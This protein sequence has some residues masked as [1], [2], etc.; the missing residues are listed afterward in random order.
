MS[1]SVRQLIHARGV[2]PVLAA[3]G[4]GLALVVAVAPAA[5][6]ALDATNLTMTKVDTLK[7]DVDADGFADPG[8]TIHYTVRL[9]NTGGVAFS[10]TVFTDTIDA[11]T[12]LV[13]GSVNV[14]PLAFDD[15]YDTIGNTL[16]RV[17]GSSTAG[18]EVFVAGGSVTSNDV[19]FLGD[20]FTISSFSATSAN[21]GTVSVNGDGTFT[22]LPPVGFS[23][24]DT[25]T[26]TLRDDGTDSTPGNG[27]DLTGGG[28]VTINVLSMIWYV[29]NDATAGGLGRSSDPFDT[30]VEAQTASAINHTIYVFTGNG[31]T[32]GQNAGI[33][34]K[35][36]QR[37]V[38][39]GVALTMPIS[40]NGGPNPFT[41]R[42][43]GT[44]PRVD[45]VNVGGSGVSAT[46]VIPI[47]M[48]GLSLSGAQNAIDM[49]LTGAFG[50]T[51]TTAIKNNIFFGAGIEGLD[52][53][54]G[55]TGTLTLDI[56]TNSW[57]TAGSHGGNGVDIQR[58]AG[59]L[60]TSFSSNTSVL[61]TGGGNA[62]VIGGGA[63]AS[64]TITGF[65]DNTVNLAST[66]TGMNI[67]NVT[68]DAVPGGSYQQVSGGTTVV[69]A[70]GP[71]NGVAG[72]GVV[73]TTVNGDLAFTDLDIYADSGTGLGVTG[74]GAVNTGAGT[75]TRVTVAS[76]VSVIEATG[77]PA[78]AL[79]SM[80]ADLQ[81]VSLR[82][83]NS[84]ST[85]VLLSSVV[86][87]TTNS[88][89]SAGSTSSIANAGTTDVSISSGNA[90]VT[91]D[92]TITDDVGQ[93]VSVASNTGDTISFRGAITDGDDTDGGGVSLTGN[94]G[95][96]I[97]F[98]GGLVL[99]TSGN[100]A[101]AAT[102]GGTINVCDENPCNP[103]ATGTHVNKIE[104]TTATAL[105][106]A[107][108]MIGAN[109]LE[110]RSI[111]AGTGAGSSGVGISLDTT[112]TAAGNGGLKVAGTGSAG[113]GGTIQHKTGANASTTA[114]IGIYL[115][116][117]KA[118]SFTRMQLND[119]DN[120][121]IRAAEIDGLTLSNVVVSGLNGNSASD[122]EGAIVLEDA[123][124]TIALS[125]INVTGGFED[126]LRVVYDNAAAG[127]AATY[128]VTGSTF[129]DLQAAGQN[130]QVNL[131]STTTA[132]SSWNVAF[133]F[134]SS[135]VFENDANTLPPGGTEN[136]TD[137]ILV[138]FE[139]PFQHS[140][141]VRN[142]TFHHLFQGMDIASNFSADVN[143]TFV[144]NNITFTEGVAAIAM[145]S[146]SS[147]TSSSFL[148]A[149]IQGNNI[150]TSGVAQSGSRLGLGIVLDM[151]GEEIAQFTLHANNIRRTEVNGIQVIG[152]TVADGNLH[153]QLT[154]NLIEQIEDD[155]GGGAGVIYGVE[156]TTNTGTSH[157]ICLDARLN[158]SFNINAHDIR[159]RQSNALVTFDIEGLTGSGTTAA[160][161]EAFLV[162]Q[163]PGNTANVRTGAS[164]VNYTS[165]VSC[166]TPPNE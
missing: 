148:T 121:A 79:T 133:N 68:F 57:N 75:G 104:T 49:T 1:K 86:D 72:S 38:G 113:S 129:R 145:G 144:G 34:L 125:S 48:V 97:N 67:S 123:G 119:F 20:S 160:N 81:L 24:V 45:N 88:T 154:N 23:G 135:C 92:G 143:Y 74:S 165:V 98:Q 9:T 47:E 106:V 93:L 140:L 130:S 166:T 44:H 118:A 70:V 11:N 107:N 14:S 76:G 122:D 22:Y 159:V 31:T 128:N 95:A 94:T 21:G 99:D 102:G 111:T 91:Y 139:G 78:L 3:I 6:S 2:V 17:G 84:T 29:K 5:F 152:Q 126:N 7:T 58:T 53:N 147:S 25:F 146:G 115:N 142:S 32:A 134:T 42:A 77:G 65:A 101:F 141:N 51:G 156:V 27:D 137:G 164:I 59:T 132:S 162:A 158:D 131:K 89:I 15:S 63:V 85:G 40:V 114:G 62:I 46:D 117:T 82:S 151:R 60:R 56:Q 71:G 69:G 30:L 61:S 4:L 19:E 90:T 120:F 110:F 55:G 153:L 26:Y 105:N 52:V 103:G 73:M 161:V 83:T 138:T 50:G 18:P 66:G 80:T 87:G 150:G 12:A 100:P 136:F 127:P 35:S 149:L 10:N 155:G 33:A 163:N 64:T 8:D 109:N 39:E 54:M 37:L 112:G 116:K 13:G 124:G 41:L 96:T 108:T 28:T 36:G 43:A 16:L 157:D